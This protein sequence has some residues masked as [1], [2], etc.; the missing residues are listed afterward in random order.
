VSRH[1]LV[2][3]GTGLVGTCVVDA[4]LAD[5]AWS[6]VTALA[7]R[8]IERVGGKFDSRVVDFAHLEPQA[9]PA[10]DDVFCCLG[11]TIRVAGSRAAFRRADHDY[12][13]AVAKAALAAGATQFLFISAL[14]A[15]AQSKVFYSRVKGE[16][17][18]DAAALPF[19]AV[20]ALRPSLLAG[21]RAEY[22]AGER[23]AL[24][25]LM[26][27]RLLVPRNYRPIAARAVARAMV[28]CAKRDV[29]GFEVLESGALQ[30]YADDAGTASR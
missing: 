18:R 30:A 16:L 21:A 3:G 29:R 27:L 26:P 13:L 5:P 25:V 28:D 22:R 7:R 17:E 14:G 11:T 10:V 24:A 20:I 15:D 23:L 2:V 12:P 1:A 6:R 4:L 19:R 9:V 8:P